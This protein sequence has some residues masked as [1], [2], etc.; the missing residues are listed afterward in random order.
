MSRA[1]VPEVFPADVVL[2]LQLARPQD[3]DMRCLHGLIRQVREPGFP[4]LLGGSQDRCQ[5]RSLTGSE[6]V[7]RIDAAWWIIRPTTLEIGLQPVPTCLQSTGER[8]ADS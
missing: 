6:G 5:I 4:L 2:V 3:M 7:P 8:G 1:D